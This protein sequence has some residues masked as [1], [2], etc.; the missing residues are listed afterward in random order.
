M[1]NAATIL[2]SRRPA[3]KPAIRKRHFF[4]ACR[5][6]YE[7]SRKRLS[8]GIPLAGAVVGAIL[9]CSATLP[10]T[11]QGKDPIRLGAVL[12]MTGPG[13]I[14]GAAMLDAINLAV[15]EIN[16]ADGIAGR[17]IE[18]IQ[19][20]DQSDPT[21]AVGETKRLVYEKKADLLIG[22]GSTQVTLAAMPI[23]NEAKIPVIDA[24]ASTAVT[25]KVAPYG[26]TPV[27]DADTNWTA[28]V[29]YV[30]DV[31]RAKS[32]A[33]LSDNGGLSKS[34]REELRTKLPARNIEIVGQEEHEIR[35]PD[36]IPQLL[37]LR[38]ANPDVLFY[39]SSFG[40]DAGRVV[41]S[42]SDLN[43]KIKVIGGVF[44]TLTPGVLK[45][46]PD[47]YKDGNVLGIT[48]TAFT[49]CT[50]D[51]IGQA[52][53]S[54]FLERLKAFDPANFDKLPTNSVSFMYDGVYLLKAAVE[55]TNSTS[56]P[57]VAA[58]IEQ[59]GAAYKAIT[60]A[61]AASAERHSLFHDAAVVE[62]ADQPRS[63]GLVKRAGC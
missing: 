19:A 42:L 35:A 41:N 49:Y 50:G 58:W 6:I 34:S 33:I 52:P 13:A 4:E 23:I 21:I 62:R 63:D 27:A 22:F 40:E 38:R 37:T 61:V 20:D 57:V 15:K 31:L 43:W 29:A 46:A 17:P 1:G 55:A 60:G 8:V 54:K 59:K 12:S 53:F 32:A 14:G 3:Q 7:L 18:I 10:A 24:T 45:V 11:A 26:F 28:G 16:A 51:P 47:A 5:M 36:M 56:G 48:Y 30:A 2:S 44:S 25:P 39:I 9:C